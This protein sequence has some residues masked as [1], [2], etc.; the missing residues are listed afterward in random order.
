MNYEALRGF[1]MDNRYPSSQLGE[2]PFLESILDAV[3][4]GTIPFQSELNKFGL[5]NGYGDAF[6]YKNKSVVVIG[7]PMS[8]KTVLTRKFCEEL[9]ETEVA[10]DHLL[11]RV[12]NETEE[13]RVGANPPLL[14]ETPEEIIESFISYLRQAEGFPLH[15]IVHLEAKEQGREGLIPPVR[16]ALREFINYSP[17]HPGFVNGFARVPWITYEVNTD[18]KERQLDKMVKTIYPRLKF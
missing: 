6:G 18:K 14:G 17:T 2:N 3:P 16:G 5:A 8:G 11:F 4:W 7:E 10:L 9:P 12:D 1:L 15:A 13:L